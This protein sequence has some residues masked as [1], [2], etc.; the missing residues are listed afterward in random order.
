M[1]L[2]VFEAKALAEALTEAGHSV[3][4]RTAQRWKAGDTAPKPQDITAIWRL[5]GVDKPKSPPAWAEGL[6]R[7]TVAEVLDGPAMDALLDRAMERV[8]TLR[9]EQSQ[10][11]DEDPESGDP[12]DADAANAQADDQ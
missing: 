8:A 3:S 6:V 9:A 10:D 7:M 4:E 2:R 5:L 1:D 11:H 12:P